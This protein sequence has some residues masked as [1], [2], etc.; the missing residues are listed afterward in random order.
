MLA[1]ISS[2]LSLLGSFLVFSRQSSHPLK[3]GVFQVR[4]FMCE[5]IGR[6]GMLNLGNLQRFKQVEKE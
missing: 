4:L 2:P 1:K 5:V 3:L 6:A